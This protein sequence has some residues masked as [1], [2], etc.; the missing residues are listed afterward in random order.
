MGLFH[1]DHSGTGDYT[2]LQQCASAL[3][4]GEEGGRVCCGSDCGPTWNVI[5]LLFTFSLA[6]L[7]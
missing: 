4:M 3:R 6:D 7:I 5:K 2:H 1:W